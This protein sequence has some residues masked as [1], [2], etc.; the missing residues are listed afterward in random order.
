MKQVV[1][2]IIALVVLGSAHAQDVKRDIPYIKNADKLQTLDVYSPS[3]GKGL[4]VVFWIHGGGWQAGDKSEV[5]LKPQVFNDKGFVFVSTNYRLLP[6]VDMA[7]LT[8]DVAKS[9][10]WVHDHIAEFGGDPK[11]FL[12]MGHSAGAQLAALLCTDERYL[13]EEGL[14]FAIIKGCVP[15][16]GDTYDIPAMI[17]VA[18]MRQRL[19]GLPLPKFG[20]RIKFG[21]DPALHKAFSAVTHVAKDKGIP[22]FLI[23]YVANHPDVT[24]QAL[25]LGNVLKAADVP[26]TLFGAKETTHTRI[27]ADLGRSD[28]AATTALFGFVEK[29]VK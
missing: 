9:I 13:K 16:D 24:A 23:L 1:S 27:N 15:V 21:N 19:H 26:V 2:L 25:R 6:H 22:P 28:D 20:H 4:P 18:E 14:S 11:R 5:H 7:T 29:A 10:R 8:R 3:N 12:I 17:E